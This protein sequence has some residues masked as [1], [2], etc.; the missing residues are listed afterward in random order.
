MPDL[1]AIYRAFDADEPLPAGD[2]ERYVDLS[3]VRGDSKIAK[4]LANRVLNA[5]DK[6][7]HHLLMG[8]NKC[9][10]TTEL[11]R[12]RHFLEQHDYVT[13][14]FDVAE[15]SGTRTFEYTTVLLHL[16]EQVVLQ[17]AGKG[18]KVE[19]KKLKK[20]TDFLREKE[21]TVGGQASGEASASSEAEAGAGLLA[22]FLGKVGFGIEFKG[23]FQRS[24]EITTR[25]EADA[26][27][28]I[29]AVGEL[30]EDARDKVLKKRGK[31]YK[32]L[33]VICDGCDKLVLTASDGSGKNYDLQYAL[34]VDHASDLRAVPCH[35][36]YTVPLSI[37]VNV[38]D[39]WEQ[40][41]EFVPA[42]PVTT[43]PGV[44]DD[45]PREGRK[46]L[47]EIVTRRLAQHDSTIDQLFSPPDMLDN[48]IGVSGGHISDLLL[49]VREAVLEAQTEEA[50]RVEQ[51]YVNRS[52]RSRALEYTRLIESSYLDTLLE[53][54]R[55]KT[56]QSNNSVYRE[57][58]FKRLAL[59][60]VCEKDNR[61]DLH[62]LVAASEAYRRHRGP[63]DQ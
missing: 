46:A 51:I 59:E 14:F 61:V 38:G 30:V 31:S 39:V 4:R 33:V 1:A 52:V 53:I 12:T 5:G 42:I 36:I 9:G 48:L 44:P 22:S 27:G 19:E 21:I 58:I 16:A 47:R 26:R 49:L 17:L 6:P 50:E 7:S 34:F 43:L 11:N 63:I 60:Y 41:Y 62:P 15:L 40:A 3:K 28:F 55:F 8:H 2:T 54:D 35:V 20:L 23:G 29:T 24:R 10:K 57:V 32:G 56:A 45:Y 13:V 18:I 25:I 37:S